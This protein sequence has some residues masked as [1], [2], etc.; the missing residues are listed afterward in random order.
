MDALY[1]QPP[2]IC[3][4]PDRGTL[5]MRRR[6]DEAPVLV[7][8]SCGS[9]L[10]GLPPDLLIRGSSSLRSPPTNMK[11]TRAPLREAAYVGADAGGRS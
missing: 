6:I 8:N 4:L 2:P 9:Q 7:K 11:L 3:D 1:R 10:Y 5:Q